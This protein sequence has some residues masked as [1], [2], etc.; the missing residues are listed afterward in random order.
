[1]LVSGLLGNTQ[2]ANT[3]VQTMK[4]IL[5]VALYLQMLSK[6]PSASLIQHGFL[7]PIVVALPSTGVGGSPLSS[8]QSMGVKM[9][10][11][12]ALPRPVVS[13]MVGWPPS[14]SSSLKVG[15]SSRGIDVLP[16]PQ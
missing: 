16:G 11:V 9:M 5:K 13:P 14:L 1:L 3:V 8:A 7:L 6:S 12:G 15:E 2:S 4:A 10:G